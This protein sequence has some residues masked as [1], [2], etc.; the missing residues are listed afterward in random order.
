MKRFVVPIILFTLAACSQAPGPDEAG[1]VP[2]ATTALKTY[3][4]SSEPIANPERGFYFHGGDCANN[5][6]RDL[7]LVGKR[8]GTDRISLVL[9]IFYLKGYTDKPLDE[10]RITQFRNQAQAVRDAGLKMIVRFAYTEETTFINNVETAIDAPVSRVLEHIGQLKSVLQENQDVIAVVESGF[11]GAWG[12]GHFSQNFGNKGN[13]VGTVSEI[14]ANWSN[15]K[16][17]VDELLKILP[18]RMVLVRTPRMKQA[19]YPGTTTGENACR[20]PQRLLSC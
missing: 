13:T 7:G 9:C 11:V 8:T 2:L 1:N 10:G 3:A 20:A 19:M 6:F 18:N 12:E 4:V 16:L 5:N 17:V 14:T 15:R